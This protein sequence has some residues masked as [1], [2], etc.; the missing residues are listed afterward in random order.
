[1]RVSALFIKTGAAWAAAT[2][3]LVSLVVMLAQVAGSLLH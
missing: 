1:L 2:L 3:N